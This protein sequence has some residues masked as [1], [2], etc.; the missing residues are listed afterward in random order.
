MYC[1]KCGKETRGSQVFCQGC[2]TDMEKYPVK[3]GTAI[4]L[5]LR[6]GKPQA[7]KSAHKARSLS[8]EEQ[9]A[10]LR[11]LV[12]R[13]TAAVAALVLALCIVA[14]VLVHMLMN[15]TGDSRVGQNYSAISS[16][17]LP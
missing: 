9:V 8:P 13:L 10:R 3:P 15:R 16:G 5:P 14:A 4:Q 1:L 11:R 17:R 2:L 7:Q 12:R 6:P